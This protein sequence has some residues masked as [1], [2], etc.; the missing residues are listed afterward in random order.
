M[1]KLVFSALVAMIALAVSA[2]ERRELHILSANDIHAAIENMPRLGFVADS[3]RGS[4]P[5][6]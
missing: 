1:K 3:L 6:F 5:T 4:I 2:Q